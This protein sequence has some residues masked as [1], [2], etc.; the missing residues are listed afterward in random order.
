MLVK[1]MTI[2]LVNLRFKVTT[3][4]RH[5]SHPRI[6]PKGSNLS[7]PTRD[8]DRVQKHIPYSNT[9]CHSSFC[10]YQ[11]G[12]SQ[13]NQNQQKPKNQAAGLLEILLAKCPSVHCTHSCTGWLQQLTELHLSKLQCSAMERWSTSKC[14]R[15]GQAI[16]PSENRKP[17][18]LTPESQKRILTFVKEYF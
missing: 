9:D 8:H 7:L 14:D 15:S 2:M 17:C 5:C 12:V 11:K 16:S 10:P 1:K 6:L 18:H 4:T 3:D 13:R